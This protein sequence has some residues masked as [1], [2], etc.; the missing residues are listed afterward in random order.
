MLS[1]LQTIGAS[2]TDAASKLQQN[3]K[4]TAGDE[5]GITVTD[6]KLGGP[7]EAIA[8]VVAADSLKSITTKLAKAI[9]NSPSLKGLVSAVSSNEV[10]TLTSTSGDTI[11]ALFISNGA[12]ELIQFGSSAAVKVNTA[13]LQVN[14]MWYDFA[15]QADYVNSTLQGGG[16]NGQ[17]KAQPA[18]A[19]GVTPVLPSLPYFTAIF[20]SAP[21]GKNNIVAHVTA[22]ETGHELDTIYGTDEQNVYSASAPFQAALAFDIAQLSSP[23]IPSCSFDASDRQNTAS[24]GDDGYY[25]SSGTSTPNKTGGLAGLF[26]GLKDADGHYICTSKGT[27]R[28]LSKTYVGLDNLHIITAAYPSLFFLTDPGAS[29]NF[30]GSELF[31]EEYSVVAGFSDLTD[32]SGASVSGSDT[33]LQ[34]GKAFVCTL[35]YVNSQTSTGEAPSALQLSYTSYYVPNTFAGDKYGVIYGPVNPPD[36]VT[37]EIGPST[38]RHNC[39]GTVTPGSTYSFGQ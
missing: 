6:P 9:N 24:Q 28:T 31:A 16:P 7:V 1:T 30:Q 14:I 34:T 26:T 38:M 22:H 12:T 11:Y 39:D 18:G 15:N 2:G 23:E 32:N 19:Y 36:P 29:P 8:K 17:K 4:I 25:A 20:E 35:L 10:I 33:I 27:G 13:T 37:H 5:I 21:V 3:S